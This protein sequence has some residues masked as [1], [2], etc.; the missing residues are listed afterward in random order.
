[1]IYCP[2]LG[3]S[4]QCRVASQ[5]AECTVRA[6]AKACAACQEDGNPQAVNVVTIGMALVQRKRLGKSTDELKRLIRQYKAD[7]EPPISFR[8]GDYR[9]GPGSELKK[10]LA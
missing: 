8:I 6:S 4:N 7:A 3:S 5:I 9:P 10:M 1:M 2:H